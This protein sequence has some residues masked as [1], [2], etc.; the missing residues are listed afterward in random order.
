MSST[1]KTSYS[2]AIRF[3]TA[4]LVAG[5]RSILQHS[6]RDVRKQNRCCCYCCNEIAT[7]FYGAEDPLLLG[8]PA[9]VLHEHLE[10][11]IGELSAIELPEC[12]EPRDSAVVWARDGFQLVS[13][14]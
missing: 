14:G 10:C 7:R 11:T 13:L 1:I 4:S 3:V 12:T 5:D 9:I 2:S 8:V 6:A